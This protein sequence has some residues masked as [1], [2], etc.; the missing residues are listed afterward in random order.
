MVLNFEINNNFSTL[1]V[2]RETFSKDVKHFP[3]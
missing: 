2:F 1:K 3:S